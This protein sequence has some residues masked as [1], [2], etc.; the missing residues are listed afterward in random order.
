[1]QP[2]I[3]RQQELS[4]LVRVSRALAETFAS[5]SPEK[6]GALG[7]SMFCECV[8]CGIFINGRELM[9]VE[10]IDPDTGEEGKLKRLRMGYC[11]RKGCNSKSYRLAFHKHPD[12]DW[13]AVLP[14]IDGHVKQQLEQVHK[15]SGVVEANKR[16]QQL[17]LAKKVAIWVAVLLFLFAL[18]QYYVGG[19]IP[20][21]RQAEKFK[22]EVM[23]NAAPHE[24]EY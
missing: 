11:A 8:Q 9:Q 3:A 4:S 13:N 24:P 17:Q 19:T 12:L 1:M 10:A 22:V 7:E 6:L 16:V 18:R 2:L 5:A 23:T 15:D 21:I 20:V 14:Q